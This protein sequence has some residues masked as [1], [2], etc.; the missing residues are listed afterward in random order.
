MNLAMLGAGIAVLHLWGGRAS[1][2]NIDFNI[3]VFADLLEIAGKYGV[4]ITVEN[5]VCNTG[6]PLDHL[7]KLKK[8]YGDNAKF[9]I[10]V[11]HAEFHKILKETCEADYLWE[12]VLHTHIADYKG[13]RMD[14]TKLRPVLRPGAGDVD[15]AY[16]FDFIK[17]IGYKGSFALE[18][19]A[20]NAE[21][22]ALDFDKLNESLDFIYKGMG[23]QYGR[24]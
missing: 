22:T 19:G 1:D 3:A 4:I 21:G 9:I 8:K 16:F 24:N 7:Y 17:R 23:S 15:F 13:D 20:R 11:R 12:N 14:W 5:V 6:S 10:D 18:A 2:K